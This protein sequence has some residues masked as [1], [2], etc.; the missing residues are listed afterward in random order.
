MS[1]QRSDLNIVANTRDEL[2]AWWS[3]DRR[4]V[5]AIAGVAEVFLAFGMLNR[6]AIHVMA[7]A[8]E[9]DHRGEGTIGE[10]DI[11]WWCLVESP[12][13]VLG[14]F[15]VLW[16]RLTTAVLGYAIFQSNGGGFYAGA[17]LYGEPLYL[18]WLLI[19]FNA[20]PLML[21]PVFWLL[22]EK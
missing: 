15:Q 21:D 8:L 18:L 12:V 20:V 16:A 4:V 9:L 7:Y 19:V 1:F 11:G 10:G 22:A 2:D 6:T 17:M 3:S 13:P 5:G 14:G